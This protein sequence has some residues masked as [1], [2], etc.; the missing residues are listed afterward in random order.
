MYYDVSTEIRNNNN[1]NIIDRSMIRRFFRRSSQ[2]AP[3][4][5]DIDRLRRI[6]IPC[7]ATRADEPLA[8]TTLFGSR[9]PS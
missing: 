6:R 7:T 1:N 9:G 8:G 3:Q 5:Y 4:S 2:L